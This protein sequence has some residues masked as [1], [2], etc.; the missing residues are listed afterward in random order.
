MYR[1]F[2]GE[3]EN[4]FDGD[5]Q[6]KA[7]FFWFYEST[8]ETRFTQN[9]NSYWRDFFSTYGLQERFM[10]L[11]TANDYIR[12]SNK[13]GV[14]DLWKEYLFREKLAGMEKEYNNIIIV[15]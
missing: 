6:D 7:R 9:D 3:S 2:K 13:K 15:R 5:K 1:F 12:P 10:K 11:L 14:F 8:F 4:P